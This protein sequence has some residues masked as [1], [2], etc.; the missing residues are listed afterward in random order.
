MDG[1]NQNFPAN[2]LID[3]MTND[4]GSPADDD[5][6]REI[7]SGDVNA[8]EKLLDKYQDHVLR[9][10]AR[11]I[12]RL[13]IEDTA[14]EVFINIFHSLPSFRGKS[15]L[16]H[17][18]A[19]VAIKTCYKFWRTHYKNREQPVSS[20][21]I[22]HRLWLEETLSSEAEQSLV[23]KASQR[24][25]GEI[26]ESALARLSAEDRMVL[27]L[28]YLEDYSVKDAARLLGWSVV[29]VKVRSFRAR[30]KLQKYLCRTFPN[31]RGTK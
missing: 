4:F 11:H 26:L 2:A 8:F 10:V 14:Q 13:H 30:Q 25:A 23:E 31:R 29:N 22:N 19:A 24:E 15:R 20:L 21:S 28:I 5:I 9:I 7:I 17:W 27:E 12:P 16:D 3:T 1:K 6:V 18:M